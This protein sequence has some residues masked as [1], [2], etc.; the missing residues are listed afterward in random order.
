MISD[1]KQLFSKWFGFVAFMCAWLCLPMTASAADDEPIIEF[2]TIV[3]E[4]A[5]GSS[6]TVFLGGFK[7][8]TDYLDFDCGSGLEEQELKQAELNTEDGTWS[9]GLK[10]TCTPGEDGVVKI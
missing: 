7:E 3:A 6:V 8:E 4:K 5:G 1:M 10:F 9:G 2:K